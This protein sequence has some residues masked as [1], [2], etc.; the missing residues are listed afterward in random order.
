MTEEQDNKNN[1]NF[2]IEALEEDHEETKAYGEDK[3]DDAEYNDSV[4]HEN[5]GEGRLQRLFC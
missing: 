5:Y 2:D 1:G 4:G 3:P